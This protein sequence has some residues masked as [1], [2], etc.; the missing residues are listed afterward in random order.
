MKRLT[1]ISLTILALLLMTAMPGQAERFHGGGGHGRGFGW[2]PLI[3]LG[4]GLGILGLTYPYYGA[5]YHP[6][7]GPAPM[8]QD[9]P[10]GSYEEPEPPQSIEPDY[11]YFCQNPEGYYPY[12]K[13]CPGGWMKVVPAPPQQ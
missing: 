12:L 10:Y 2:G 7:Y 8:V 9:P 6:G 13:H 4:V 5:P 1:G 3:G 11:W